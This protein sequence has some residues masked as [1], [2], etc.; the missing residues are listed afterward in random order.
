[1]ASQ[2]GQRRFLFGYAI[3][4]I[5]FVNALILFSQVRNLI[6]DQLGPDCLSL[7]I[8]KRTKMR[9]SHERVDVY[10]SN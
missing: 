6:L 5:I 4:N 3:A 7:G 10:I 1:M 8:D 9:D 2:L